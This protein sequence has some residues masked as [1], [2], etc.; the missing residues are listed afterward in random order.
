VS[1]SE[2]PPAPDPDAFVQELLQRKFP[3]NFRRRPPYQFMFESSEQIVYVQNFNKKATHLWYRVNEKPWQQLQSRSS[4]GWLCL[5][6]PT[7]RYVYIFPV[8][9]LQTQL[10]QSD[11]SRTYLEVNIDPASH[12]WIELD[13]KI[14]KYLVNL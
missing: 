12:R 4:K 9:D 7:E 11:W 10:K 14:A 1:S 13:W 6:N 2:A 8:S 3:G 5:T